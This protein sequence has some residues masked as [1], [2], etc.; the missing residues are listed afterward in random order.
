M[1]APV[2]NAPTNNKSSNPWAATWCSDE[3]VQLKEFSSKIFF[4]QMETLCINQ[5][6]QQK[7]CVGQATAKGL[8]TNKETVG[9]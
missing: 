4:G 9:L 3:G 2:T 8:L 5:A 6:I 7:L 1:N